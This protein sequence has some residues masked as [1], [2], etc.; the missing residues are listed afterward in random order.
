MEGPET[1]A[2]ARNAIRVGLHLVPDAQQ[3]ENDDEAQGNAEKPEKHEKHDQ[4]LP[5]FELPASAA[6]VR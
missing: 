6:R 1:P 2:I 5:Y 4:V 3:E